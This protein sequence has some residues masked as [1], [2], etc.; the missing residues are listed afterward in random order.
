MEKHLGR[1][2]LA[3]E[4]IHHK[5]GNKAD[6]RIE[7]FEII[8]ENVHM[9]EYHCNRKKA[10]IDWNKIKIPQKAN[11]WHPNKIKQCIIPK[12]NKITYNRGLCLSHYFRYIRHHSN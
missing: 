3:S 1:K 11:R 2:L 4:H 5:N 7:N 12:C 6:N 8:T 10:D 9:S